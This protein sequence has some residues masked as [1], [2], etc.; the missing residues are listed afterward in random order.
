[1]FFAR[2]CFNLI[3]VTTTFYAIGFVPA[4]AQGPDRYN[5]I[6]HIESSNQTPLTNPDDFE[7]LLFAN[8]GEDGDLFGRSVSYS[9]NR[10]LVG[11]SRDDDSGDASGSAY[12]FVRKDDSW[13]QEAKLVA[14]DG[15]EFDLFGHAVS[16]HGDRALVGAHSD[17]DGGERSGSAYV[18][19]RVGSQWVQEAKL[20]ASDATEGD[21]FGWSVS[22]FGD[23]ALVGAYDAEGGGAAYVFARV[24][25]GWTQEAKLVATDASPNDRFG[26]SVSLWDGRALIGADFDSAGSAYVFARAGGGWIQEAKLVS[27]DGESADFF[28]GSVS[29]SE[30][31]AL[32]GATGDKEGD[33]PRRGAAYVF[34]RNGPSWTQE[35]KLSAGDSQSFGSSVSLLGGYAL[36]GAPLSSSDNLFSGSAYLFAR[37]ETEWLQES[38]FTSQKTASRDFFGS[39]VS[40]SENRAIVG[41]GDPTLL[42][43]FKDTDGGTDGTPAYIFAF[44]GSTEVNSGPDDSDALSPAVPNPTARYSKFFLTLESP[45]SVRVTLSDARGREVSDLFRGLAMGEMQID[46]DVSGLTPGV[47]VVRVEGETFAES[48]TVTVV[49]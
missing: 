49:R 46:V 11:A 20:S 15:A 45:Q 41:L 21:A 23:R 33:G 4:D 17:D 6:S 26:R 36:V 24:G 12:I 38:R 48:R 5:N 35:T 22:L 16:L 32:V 34:V 31:R 3:Y 28:G 13:T 27:S 30:T 7:T 47:Y 19:S 18:F 8:D 44:A 29:I 14:D 39:A 37:S 10:V 2:P 40:L 25:S 9:G 1:M 42:S 43:A